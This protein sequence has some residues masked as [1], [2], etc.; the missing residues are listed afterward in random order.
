MNYIILY[1]NLLLG[2]GIGSVLCFRF[3]LFYNYVTL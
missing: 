1:N 2:A 3:I